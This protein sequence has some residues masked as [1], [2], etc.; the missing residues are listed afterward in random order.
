M[1][2]SISGED[3]GYILKA[4]FPFFL[5]MIAIVVVVTLFPQ[6]ATWLPYHMIG[7]G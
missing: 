3:I 5:I 6:I 2:Q 4:T 7:G 1:I